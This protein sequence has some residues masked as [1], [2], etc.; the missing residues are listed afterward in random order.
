MA[1]CESVIVP[2]AKISIVGEAPGKDEELLGRPFVGQ[3]GQE[4]SRMLQSAG[5]DI[6][7]CSL[8]Y[9]FNSSPP[10]GKIENF[11]GS[12]KSCGDNYPYPPLS[13]G[14]Y[15]L[16]VNLGTNLTR[17]KSEL[18]SVKPNLILALGNAAAWALLGQGGVGAIRGTTAQSTLC[19][20]KVLPTY[21][22]SAV[23]RNWAFRPVTLMDFGKAEKEQEFAEIIRPKREVWIDPS[24]TDLVTFEREFIQSTISIDIE[25]GHGLIKCVGIGA[26]PSHALI[27]PFTDFRSPDYSYWPTPR[28]ERLAW[29]WVKHLMA[30]EDLTKVFQNGM[31]DMQWLWKKV[32]LPCKGK[33]EDTM[34]MHHALQPEMEKSLGFLGSIYTNESSW[35][36]L[37][38]KSAKTETT[39]R[40]E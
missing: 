14:K 12:K 17:L 27:V 28:H 15:F 23:M 11:C 33:I 19:G 5:I 34:L 8:H 24:I 7:S 6:S 3:A 21:S 30:R 9:V 39:K 25:T 31:Y 36:L 32:G 29:L 16:P 26:S 2:G 37:R 40:D 13:L 1:K 10:G 35:K 38:G 20:I 22:P 4:L 18:L